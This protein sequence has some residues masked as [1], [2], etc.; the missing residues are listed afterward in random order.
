MCS[1]LYKSRPRGCVLLYSSSRLAVFLNTNHCS[2]CLEF[3]H[4]EEGGVC[5]SWELFDVSQ[6]CFIHLGLFN[7]NTH[8]AHLLNDT[9]TSPSHHLAQ[10]I[11]VRRNAGI[12]SSSEHT[13]SQWVCHDVKQELT[14]LQCRN[15]APSFCFYQ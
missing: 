10:N 12:T 11:G 7:L 14:L 8:T 15:V 6:W 13:S 1:R 2:N 5:V 4:V 9:P 3:I